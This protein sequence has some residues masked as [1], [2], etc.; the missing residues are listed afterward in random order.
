VRSGPVMA[1]VRSFIGP[2]TLPLDSTTVGR[3]VRSTCVV[4]WPHIVRL[5]SVSSWPSLRSI[6]RPWPRS[7]WLGV[8]S[9]LPSRF[10]FW[11]PVLPSRLPFRFPFWGPVLRS[12]LPF[13]LRSRFPFRGRC[14]VL[15]NR[16]P[17]SGRWH[18]SVPPKLLR[19]A[20]QCIS[21]PM[22]SHVADRWAHTH[23]RWLSSVAA[24]AA[25]PPH[26]L[27]P[28]LRNWW[29]YSGAATRCFLPPSTR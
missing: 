27:F 22:P 13:R 26:L 20:I 29:Q 28:G 1:V 10:P 23:D 2:A 5:V 19:W 21:P 9:R 6:W 4:V 11:G 7:H 15:R 25:R 8:R 16:C 24:A 3:F 14:P 18:L 12:R 17:V